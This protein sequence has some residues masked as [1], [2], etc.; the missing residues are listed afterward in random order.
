MKENEE[1]AVDEVYRSSTIGEY[2]SSTI[3]ERGRYEMCAENIS[4]KR[5]QPKRYIDLVEYF[6]R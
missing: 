4:K 5:Y 3:H 1:L 6:R 2:K